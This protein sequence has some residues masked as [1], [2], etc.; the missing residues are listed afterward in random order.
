MRPLYDSGQKPQKQ[1]KIDDLAEKC[2]EL[3]KESPKAIKDKLKKDIADLQYGFEP[4][5]WCTK[6]GDFWD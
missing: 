4:W 2:A 1:K 3:D 6:K 5:N